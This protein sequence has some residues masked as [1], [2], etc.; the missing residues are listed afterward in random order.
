MKW[1][2]LAGLPRVLAE[3]DADPVARTTSV[4]QRVPPQLMIKTAKGITDAEV[5]QAAAYF[6]G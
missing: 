2:A 1:R 3:S 4:P 6:S 5:E